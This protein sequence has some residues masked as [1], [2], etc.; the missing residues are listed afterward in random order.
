MNAKLLPSATLRL[1]R[2]GSGFCLLHVS[3]PSEV[4]ITIEQSDL[5]GTQRSGPE[6]RRHAPPCQTLNVRG[7]LP[8]HTKE[9]LTPYLLETFDRLKVKLP[10]TISDR[11]T[12]SDHVRNHGSYRTFFLFNIWDIHQADVLHRDH[13]CYCFGYLSTDTLRRRKNEGFGWYVH[14]WINKVRLYRNQQEIRRVIEADVRKACPKG[15]TFIANERA[16]EAVVLQ[17]WRTAAGN[18]KRS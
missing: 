3:F 11:L 5:P 17:L 2:A 15:F 1:H 7:E 13:F 16:V 14:L 10:A 6:Q 12:S 9:E 18:L 8:M 4:N